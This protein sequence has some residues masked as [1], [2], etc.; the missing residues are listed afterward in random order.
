MSGCRCL[1][2][3]GG[4]GGH[5]M[6]GLSV[7]N[8]LIE[9]GHLVYWVGTG[10]ELEKKLISSNKAINFY[11]YK[12]K[13]FRGKGLAQKVN[14][15]FIMVY[16]LV[17]FYFLIIKI[18]PQVVLGMG[19]YISLP[20]GIAAWLARV[21]LIIHEQNSIPGSANKILR[22]L[23]FR[24]CQGLTNNGKSNFQ[25]LQ[26]GN[27]VREEITTSMSKISLDDSQFKILVIGGSQGSA[28]LNV[29]IPTALGLIKETK[30]INVRHQAGKGKI[31]EVSYE[32]IGSVSEAAVSE[33]IDDMGGAYDWADLIICRSGALT[34]SEIMAIGGL[35]LFIPYPYA[36]DNH[37]FFNALDLK[38]KGGAFLVSEGECFVNKV[39]EYVIT[40]MRDDAVCAHMKQVAKACFIPNGA[41]VISK[42]CLEAAKQYD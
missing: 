15:L 33:F 19:G 14:S 27:P 40:L 32:N 37:Q 3:A 23:A 24:A 18:R 26:V 16:L 13:G 29:N 30:G 31:D 4:T 17:K 38:E 34:V 25:A 12:A 41:E 2:L 6:P 36:T 35:A 21:P 20:G 22:Y 42:V 1:I 10:N 28:Y 8:H 11:S 7:A 9:F 5:I 39:S